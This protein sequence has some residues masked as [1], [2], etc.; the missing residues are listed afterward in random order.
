MTLVILIA[1]LC[2]QEG[3]AAA[4]VR[5]LEEAQKALGD[6]KAIAFD[7]ELIRVR[8]GH[9][10]EDR[11]TLRC[12]LRKPNLLRLEI[13]SEAKEGGHLVVLDGEHLWHLD[14]AK[15]EYVKYDQDDHNTAL[16]FQLRIPAAIL[17]GTAAESLRRD[18]VK[19]V[20][21][22]REK[23]KEAD[24]TVVSWTGPGPLLRDIPVEEHWRLYL[25]ERQLPKRLV[26]R[27]TESGVETTETTTYSKYDLSPKLDKE[28]F[29][30]APP[31][32]AK[33][34]PAPGSSK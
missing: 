12:T 32:G 5:R 21:V 29:T 7:E 33:E 22:G 16:H 9:H 30:F 4:A 23:I 1:G 15:K 28:T 24:C 25:D 34:K 26:R 14:R 19:E 17:L 13:G 2:L 10:R 27:W 20:K 11:S 31:E 18:G 8:T 6:R 3:D